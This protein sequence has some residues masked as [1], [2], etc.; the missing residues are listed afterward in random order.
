VIWNWIPKPLKDQTSA[1]PNNL[2]VASGKSIQFFSYSGTVPE[3]LKTDLPKST[4]TE[5]IVG[6]RVWKLVR[7]ADGSAE[8]RLQSTYKTNYTWPFRR[9]LVRDSIDKTGIHAV[10]SIARIMPMH[11]GDSSIDPF[12]SLWDTYAADVAGEVYL[13]GEVVEHQLGYLAE[14]AYPKQLWVPEDTD[15]MIV[16]EL[17]ENYGVPVTMR[18]EFKKHQQDTPGQ[19]IWQLQFLSPANCVPKSK[20][21][22]CGQDASSGIGGE[23]RVCYVKR[24]YHQN[25]WTL[26]SL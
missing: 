18:K 4:S 14:F 19:N 11:T 15:P 21:I 24:C 12:G 16:M 8:A 23:C 7:K 1:I 5:P 13:W 22:G 2:S 3:N 20:C 25:P 9:K 26:G 10:K 17:E 6:Y